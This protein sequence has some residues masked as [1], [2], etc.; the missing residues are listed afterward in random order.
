MRFSF[1]L[2]AQEALRLAYLDADV[3]LAAHTRVV[4]HLI[5]LI[6]HGPVGDAT[7]QDSQPVQR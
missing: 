3:S 2:T 6:R 7:L 5:V 1:Q 4:R